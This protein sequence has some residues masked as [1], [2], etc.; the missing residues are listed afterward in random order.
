MKA[1]LLESNRLIYEPLTQLHHSHEYVDWMNDPDV[2]R[3]LESGGD[4]TSEK[5]LYFLREVEKKNILFWAIRNK[6]NGRHIGNIKIDPVNEKYGLAEYGIMMGRKT[7]WGKG[8]AFEASKR[9]IK[10]C[11]NEINI[12]RSKF[13]KLF[14]LS[15]FE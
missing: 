1:K 2:I 3:Y 10:F 13:K 11:F 12:N 8:Y 4:Y 6:T 15:I 5:L 7:E 9:I 14:N